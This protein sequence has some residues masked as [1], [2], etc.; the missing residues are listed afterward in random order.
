MVLR[1]SVAETPTTA[2]AAPPM[3]AMV[4]GSRRLFSDLS[5][6]VPLWGWIGAVG[7]A[8]AAPARRAVTRVNFILNE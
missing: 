2:E 6:T 7:I 4:R 5:S 3:M 1:A 8:T